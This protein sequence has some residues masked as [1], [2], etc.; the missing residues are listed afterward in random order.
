MA[1]EDLAPKIF[2]D[3]IKTYFSD[4]SY[5]LIYT[6][7][8]ATIILLFAIISIYTPQVIKSLLQP[9][10]ERLRDALDAALTI[11]PVIVLDW[12]VGIV[13]A[14]AVIVKVSREAEGERYSVTESI[15][16]G[17]SFLPRLVG[18]FFICLVIILSIFLPAIFLI[19]YGILTKSFI[20]ILV[21]LLLFFIIIFPAFY[22]DLRL[23]LYQQTCIIRDKGTID[24]LKES[25]RITKGNLLFIFILL[26]FIMI[27]YFVTSIVGDILSVFSKEIGFITNL[28]LSTILVAPIHIIAL[29]KVFLEIAGTQP[30]STSS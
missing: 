28:S 8:L 17:L 16:E 14:S 6:L 4:R 19:I 3:S 18:A 9:N 20:L 22:I 13:A 27:L 21:S 5:A 15:G 23:S 24:C 2:V 1:K 10:L 30:F 29:T 25:W 7:P 26:I 11:L 12:I